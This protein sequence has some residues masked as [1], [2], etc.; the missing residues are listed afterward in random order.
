MQNVL[1]TLGLGIN[2]PRAYLRG[3]TLDAKHGFKLR[4]NLAAYAD[5]G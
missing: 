2:L 3:A 5:A 4:P 1:N